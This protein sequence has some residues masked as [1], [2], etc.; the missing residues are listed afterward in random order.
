MNAQQ[1]KPLIKK[2]DTGRYQVDDNLYLRISSSKTTSWTFRYKI[3]GKRKEA[4]QDRFLTKNEIEQVFKTL[5][6]TQ[7]SFVRQNYIACIILLCLGVRK[8]ELLAAPW[9][10]FDL[11]S[12]IWKLP[13]ERS[14]SGIPIA[15]SARSIF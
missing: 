14:K 6:D 13:K 5:K 1:V 2:T 8:D 9:S 3:N 15:R 7:D 4:S 12:K 10:E 11:E